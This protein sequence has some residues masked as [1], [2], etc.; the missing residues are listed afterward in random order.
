MLESRGSNLNGTQK[1]PLFDRTLG[2]KSKD[3]SNRDGSLNSKRPNFTFAEE[4]I[5]S[6]NGGSNSGGDSLMKDSIAKQGSKTG[7][8]TVTLAQSEKKVFIKKE[9]THNVSIK[10]EKL[11]L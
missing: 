4:T 8:K 3:G 2:T 6:R 10:N 9:L 5:P 11:L 1:P 7:L